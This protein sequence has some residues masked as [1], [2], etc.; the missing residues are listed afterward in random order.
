MTLNTNFKPKMI[1]VWYLCK[2]TNLK[3]MKNI[4]KNMNEFNENSN[5]TSLLLLL[6]R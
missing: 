5:I 2:G 4:H 1:Y 3:Q 6:S